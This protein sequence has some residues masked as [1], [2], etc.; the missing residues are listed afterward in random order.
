[1]NYPVACHPQAWAAGTLPF[2]LV[3]LLGLEPDAF[4]KR[5]R[6]VR[7]LLPQGL[8]RLVIKG[9]H[10]NRASVDLTFERDNTGVHVEVTNLDGELEV[11]VTQGV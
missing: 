3:T 7:L 1:V 6:I 10:V 4:H 11:Q 8:D 9:L 2:L 5:V